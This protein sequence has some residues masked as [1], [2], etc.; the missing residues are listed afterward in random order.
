MAQPSSIQKKTT[1][2]SAAPASPGGGVVV[3]E[4]YAAHKKVY[5]RAVTGWFAA[6][7]WALVWATQL[8]FYG[9]PWIAW[10]GSVQWKRPP[11]CGLR[12]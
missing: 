11:N 12:P 2:A 10:N 8:V 9:T 3:T 7:R 4:L 5:P 1:N 6:W